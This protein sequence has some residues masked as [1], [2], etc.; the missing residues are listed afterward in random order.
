MF[1]TTSGFN[2]SNFEIVSDFDIRISNLGNKLG[3]SNPHVTLVI[4][5]RASEDRFL[6]SV[7]MTT[8][9]FGPS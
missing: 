7:E 1:Q 8:R 6:P 2:I 9:N 3:A 5:M 4:Q